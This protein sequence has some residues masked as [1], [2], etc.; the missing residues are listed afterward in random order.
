MNGQAIVTTMADT[1]L[2]KAG[3]R[4]NL[5]VDLA[6]F[7]FLDIHI[8]KPV[9]PFFLKE[10]VIHHVRSLKM[11]DPQAFAGVVKKLGTG[12]NDHVHHALFDQVG[13]SPAHSRRNDRSRDPQPNRDLRFRKN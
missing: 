13:D 1:L 12:G 3:V 6:L 11:F 10:G 4:R 5:A 7:L 2:L 9:D 8:V